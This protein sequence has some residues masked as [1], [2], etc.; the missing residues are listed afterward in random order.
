MCPQIKAMLGVDTETYYDGTQKGLK[1]IQLY[2]TANGEK[3]EK[4]FTTDNFDLPDHMIRIEI[5]S[6]F[7]KFFEDL[8]CDADVA[9]YNIDFDVSQFLYYMTNLAGYNI[10]QS[11]DDPM[12]IVK[13][14]DMS[15]LESDVTMYS[16]TFRTKVKGKLIKFFDIYKFLPG[17]SLNSAC[18]DWLG[19]QKVDIESKLFLKSEATELEKKYAMKDAELTFKLFL[20]LSQQGV[21]EGHKYI[22]IAGRTFGHFRNFLKEEFNLTFDEFFFGTT[23]K[24]E[25][26]K[27]KEEIEQELRMSTRGGKCMAVHKGVFKNCKH[28]DAYSLYPSQCNLDF[29][30]YGPILREP[31]EDGPYITIYY[32]SGFF[33]IK[34]DKIPYF[35]W[36]RKAQCEH[37]RYLTDYVPGE[38]VND[39]LLDG[40]YALWEDEW[41]VVQDSYNIENLNIDDKIYFRLK[42]NTA[43]KAYVNMLNQGKKKNKGSKRL[44]YKYLLNSLY[45][46]FL[47]RP[48]GISINYRD[49]KRIKVEEKDRTTYYLPLGMW[50]AMKGRVCLSKAMASIDVNDVLYCDTDSII[51][52]GDKDP[53][54]PIYSD[55][56]GWEIEAENVDAYI[57]GPKTYQELFQDG[58]CK[59]KCAGMPREIIEK[60]EWLGIYEGLN[61]K[62][63]KP[64]RDKITWA[65][66]FEET[67]YTISTRAQSFRGRY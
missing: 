55:F 16:V 44:Y 54:V 38:Y 9:F 34:E 11:E 6:K 32:P 56:G 5:A 1:S 36:R 42:E 27:Y 23:N 21:I 52:K 49:G 35:Q 33:E 41:E 31:P 30:P 48:D 3:I 37:Y 43:L 28:I 46:K 60:Q 22:T 17:T 2:G 25:V 7:F 4:Y 15:I 29:I 20:T 63:S 19:E 62:V 61:L 51:Y 39:C 14:G 26:E 13:K 50:I 40:T 47:S 67:E 45:G 10:R 58:I 64:R 18:K 12:F 57:V 65:I 66:N 53:N 24:E 8:D 59:T